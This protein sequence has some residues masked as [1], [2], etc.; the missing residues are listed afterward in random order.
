MKIISA[1]ILEDI[2]RRS[3]QLRM[4]QEIEKVAYVGDIYTLCNRL[5]AAIN[6]LAG[7]A[8]MPCKGY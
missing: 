2:I 8:S 4:T 7:A 3:E 5:R 1:E 6:L